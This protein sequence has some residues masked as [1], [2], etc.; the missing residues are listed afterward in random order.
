M[1]ALPTIAQLDS[2]PLTRPQFNTGEW[3]MASLANFITA[4]Y[5]PLMSWYDALANEI[6][7]T[8]E[9]MPKA[10]EF[11]AIQFDL[12][13]ARKGLPLMHEERAADRKYAPENERRHINSDERYGREVGVKSTGEI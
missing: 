7:G 1:S 6:E 8:S 5:E 11:L 9:V 3:A 2:R 10:H 13:R 12:E 4:N